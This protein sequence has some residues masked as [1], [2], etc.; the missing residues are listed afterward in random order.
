MWPTSTFRRISIYFYLIKKISYSIHRFGC[1]AILKSCLF[2]SS[3]SI[4]KKSCPP[5]LWLDLVNIQILIFQYQYWLT[6]VILF[7]YFFFMTN[8]KKYKTLMYWEKR[9]IVFITFLYGGRCNPFAVKTNRTPRKGDVRPDISLRANVFSNNYIY[10]RLSSCCAC[11][12][13]K[14]FSNWPKIFHR[15]KF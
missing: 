4:Y 7:Y 8:S 13:S 11:Y 10:V 6:I 12:Q 15:I 1:P 9:L 2:F 14:W 5:E 3:Y